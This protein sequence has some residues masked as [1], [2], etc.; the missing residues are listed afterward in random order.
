MN[1][2]HKPLLEQA[3]AYFEAHFGCTCMMT[4][5]PHEGATLFSLR[6]TSPV[7]F[8][9]QFDP[10]PVRHGGL[11]MRAH[12]LD[13]DRPSLP[14]GMPVRSVVFSFSI[15]MV[16]ALVEGVFLSVSLEPYE[17]SGSD[18]PATP[19]TPLWDRLLTEP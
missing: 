10:D 7:E 12:N 9:F 5:I 8:D 4:E 15:G 17:P 19:A 11:I 13:P 14:N 1:P 3:R 18:P 2:A 16:L 6:P